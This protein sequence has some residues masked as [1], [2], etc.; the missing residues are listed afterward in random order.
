MPAAGVYKAP[1]QAGDQTLVFSDGT[2]V[3]QNFDT[4]MNRDAIDI[5]ESNFAGGVVGYDNGGYTRMSTHEKLMRMARD[6]YG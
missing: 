2:T 3:P 1:V 6:M 5:L 4:G